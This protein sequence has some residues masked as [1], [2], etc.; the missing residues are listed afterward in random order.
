MLSYHWPGRSEPVRYGNGIQTWNGATDV[1]VY[2]N[3][4]WQI[5]DTLITNQGQQCTQSGG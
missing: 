3:R 2:N 1:E 4:I 5:Y